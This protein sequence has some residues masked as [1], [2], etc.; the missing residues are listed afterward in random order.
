[1][2]KAQVSSGGKN[3]GDISRDRLRAYSIAPAEQCMESG[4]ISSQILGPVRRQ[5]PLGRISNTKSP[6]RGCDLQDP[7]S[8][9][10]AEQRGSGV[11]LAVDDCSRSRVPIRPESGHESDDRRHYWYAACTSVSWPE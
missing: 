8:W 9:R 7:S 4:R 6:D 10:S 2:K 3:H 11:N 5:I 1:M